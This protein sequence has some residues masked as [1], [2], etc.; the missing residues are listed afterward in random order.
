[1]LAQN[2]IPHPFR[3]MGSPVLVSVTIEKVI[4]A[5]LV[6]GILKLLEYVLAPVPSVH[7]LFVHN[8]ETYPV[9]QLLIV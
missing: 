5:I 4:N 2:A 8:T 9:G 1:M 6:I 3:N 7:W